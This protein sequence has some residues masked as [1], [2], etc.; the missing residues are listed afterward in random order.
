MVGQQDVT[1]KSPE[2]GELGE[3]SKGTFPGFQSKLNAP[4]LVAFW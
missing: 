2:K 4:Y 3:K 1:K